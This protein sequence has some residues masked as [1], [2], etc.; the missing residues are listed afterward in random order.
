MCLAFLPWQPGL[1]FSLP[2]V[3]GS[4]RLRSLRGCCRSV[5]ISTLTDEKPLR[6]SGPGYGR[7]KPFS[8]A[9]HFPT[10]LPGSPTPLFS[11]VNHTP[12]VRQPKQVKHCVCGW[13][14][15]FVFHVKWW[16]FSPRPQEDQGL[17][18]PGLGGRNLRV[19]GTYNMPFLV[20]L[21]VEVQQEGERKGLQVDI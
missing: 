17:N 6:V 5:G 2:G 7:Y 11:W 20:P 21:Q 8:R 10:I 12:T 19:Q 15:W 9:S 4:P 18:R 1:V 16:V 13:D 3:F 14:L